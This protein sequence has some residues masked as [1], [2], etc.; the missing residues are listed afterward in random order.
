MA[1]ITPANHVTNFPITFEAEIAS[2][3]GWT[4]F[5]TSCIS[6]LTE[7]ISFFKSCIK[8]LKEGVVDSLAAMTAWSNLSSNRCKSSLV[9]QIGLKVKV[10]LHEQSRRSI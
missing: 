8:W 10:Y 1:R 9:T 7:E 3:A 6:S 2:T 4:D 5:L